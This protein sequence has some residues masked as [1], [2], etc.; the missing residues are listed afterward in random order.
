MMGLNISIYT[1]LDQNFP[2]V[3]INHPYNI[4]VINLF[5]RSWRHYEGLQKH[6]EDGDNVKFYT[7]KDLKKSHEFNDVIPNIKK[8]EK[9]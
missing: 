9:K 6:Q 1:S 8:I 5:F 2:K 7:M 3:E 4:G